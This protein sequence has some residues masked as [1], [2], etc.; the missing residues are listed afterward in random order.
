MFEKTSNLICMFLVG[1][2]KINSSTRKFGKNTPNY[3]SL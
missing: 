2:E 3:I 1:D